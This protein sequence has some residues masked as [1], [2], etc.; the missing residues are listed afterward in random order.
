M[1]KQ[2]KIADI[3][4]HFGCRTKYQVQKMIDDGILDEPYRSSKSEM[5]VWTDYD[6]RRAEK[7][8]QERSEPK[9]LPKSGPRFG[10]KMLA[11]IRAKG[12]PL[13]SYGVVG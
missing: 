9:P 10:G 2:F 7:R 3:I 12:R 11:K 8:L 6:V 13:R 1:P 4:E 5:R